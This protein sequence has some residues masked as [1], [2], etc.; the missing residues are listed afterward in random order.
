MDERTE[1]AE[2]IQ[3]AGMVELVVD[4]VPVLRYL[5]GDGERPLADLAQALVPVAEVAPAVL[6]ELAGW[7]LATDDR[8]LEQELVGH[9]ATLV[10][11]AHV[12][13]FDLIADA[14][15]LDPAWAHPELS[16]PLRVTGVDRPADAFT[17]VE[18]AAFP[19]GHPDHEFADG[20][21][22]R[23]MLQELLDGATVGPYLPAASGLV[24]DG[25]RVVAFLLANRM[26]GTPPLGGPW[27]SDVAR[28]PDPAYRGVGM[29]LVRRALVALADAGE[30]AFGL[31]VSDGNPARRLYEELGFVHRHSARRLQLPGSGAGGA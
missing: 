5:R 24:L 13:S 28:L 4:G 15:R 14:D 20:A 1:P 26:T 19:P 11:H 25:E 3:P 7:Q 18:L 23:Q 2:I 22:A 27:L 6:R 30:P 9:G 17:D 31:A 10:R 8:A 16:Y 12:L 21:H 29:A